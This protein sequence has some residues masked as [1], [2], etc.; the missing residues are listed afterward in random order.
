MF[1][2]LPSLYLFGAHYYR[3]W[4]QPYYFE[5]NDEQGENIFETKGNVKNSPREIQSIKPIE[6][7]DYTATTKL[8]GLTSPDTY[9]EN[10]YLPKAARNYHD[11]YSKS[12]SRRKQ[13][14]RSSS[15]FNAQRRKSCTGD[16]LNG[17]IIYL[18]NTTEFTEEQI[19]LWHNDFLVCAN[20]L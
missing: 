13:S 3:Q 15:L 6:K 4:N 19:L 5:Q 2:L 14:N 20:N 8:T 18:M 16:L 17:D 9:E 11:G 7:Y 10:G 12:K 1:T